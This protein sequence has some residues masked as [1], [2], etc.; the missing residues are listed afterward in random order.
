M[1]LDPKRRF[2]L[3]GYG[4]H[5]EWYTWHYEMLKKLVDVNTSI[6]NQT[7]QGL[8][9][10][11]TASDAFG[12]LRTSEPFTL[13]DANA[14]YNKTTDAFVYSVTSGA[15][16][17][18]NPNQGCIDF[19][20]NTGTP[21]SITAETIRVFAYQPGK[22]LLTL[23]TF[24]FAPDQSGLT[25]RVGYYGNENG[26]Y[27]QY[28]SSTLSFVKRTKI[29]GAVS[30]VPISQANWNGDKL[31][32]SGPSGIT[33]DPTKAQILWMDIEW[34]GVGSV[35]MG[36]VINGEFI[37]CHTFHH[38]NII[39]STYMTTASLPVRYE[40]IASSSLS[41]DAIM[42]QICT[43]VIS[44]GGYELRGTQYSAGLDLGS[45]KTFVAANTF[46]PALALRLKAATP[47]GVA[48]LSNMSLVGL[49][50]SK[51]YKWRLKRLGVSSGGS[52]T[53]PSAENIVEYN[54][55]PT[56]L[57]GGEI[58]ASGYLSSSNQGSPVVNLQKS[59]IFDLQFERYNI[60]S[61]FLPYEYVLEVATSSVSGGEGVYAALDWQEIVS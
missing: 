48:V 59:S 11:P 45:F 58:V 41:S 52:W 13:F 49:G 37:L 31:D 50:N 14:R 20:I 57:S 7:T 60:G 56:S 25:Q 8:S 28:S 53:S 6:N 17:A 35:R 1:A 30:E 44:E 26:L 16:V 38:A 22:S 27:V 24:V 32:G 42:K 4:Q 47:D 29:S 55:T 54:L 46:Y 18:H 36:F 43:S 5:P 51:Y 39:D 9:F 40:L 23:N 34:L 15:A 2:Y 3:D 10:K 61:T 33:I 12:R 21:A 19:R